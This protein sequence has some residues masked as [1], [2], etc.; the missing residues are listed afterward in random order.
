MAHPGQGARRTCGA[1]QVAA[2]DHVKQERLLQEQVHELR[3]EVLT[4]RAATEENEAKR[5]QSMAERD[6][7][8]EVRGAS[9]VT[10]PEPVRR[11]AS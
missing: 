11:G 3:A 4:Q 6:A 1:P 9:A 5:S 8:F 7:M 10:L 2:E